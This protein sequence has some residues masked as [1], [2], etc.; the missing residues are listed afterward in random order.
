LSNI[1]TVAISGNLVADPEL[2]YAGANGDFAIGNLRMAV[3]RSKKTDDGYK[4]EAS[5]FSVTVLG[6]F[7]EL[8][9][10][11]ARKGD[12]ISVKGRLEEQRWETQDGQKRSK[13][14]IVAEDIDGACFFKKDEDVKAKEDGTTSSKPAAS[15]SQPAA[16]DD[17]PF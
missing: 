9:D 2:R 1:N 7:A 11:K 5:F 13:V 14:V 15:G 4:D 10:R 8:V 6:K 16:D 3:N 12:A 17:I